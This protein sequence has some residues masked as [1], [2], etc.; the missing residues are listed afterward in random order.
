MQNPVEQIAD[1]ILVMDA[2]SGCHEALEMLI[3]RWQKRLW[4][5]AYSLTLRP[6]AAW[7]ITQESWLN[8]VRGLGRL[9]D[10]AKFRSWA[11]RIVSN[12]AHDWIGRNG[13]GTSPEDEP[14]D[15]SAAPIDQ[16]QH[17]TASDVHGILRRLPGHSQVVL[18]LYYLEGF[19]LAE[20]AQILGT[21][22]GTVKSRLHAA[23]IEFRKQWET[24]DG[25]SPAPNPASGKETQHE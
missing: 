5:H 3:S 4:E 22:K 23:R 25:T 20:I 19:G 13:R 8:I 7:D 10:P 16:E 15:L 12:K 18:K 9:Q 6:E 24:L 14:E 2:Q 21:P 17:E 1:E 11:Y